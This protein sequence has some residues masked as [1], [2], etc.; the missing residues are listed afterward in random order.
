MATA[1]VTGAT[2]ILG[3]EIVRELSEDSNRWRKVYALSRSKADQYPEHVEHAHLDLTSSA[4]DM[5]KELQ[6][7]DPEYIFFSAYLANEDPDE[8][9]RINGE[10]LENFLES[11]VINRKERRLKRIVLVC[12]L[13]HYGVHL[14]NPKQPMEEDDPWIPEPPAPSNFYYRQQ[15]SL[16][17]FCTRHEIPWNVTYSNE[18]LGYAKGNFMNLAT[19]IALYAAVHAEIG[20]TLPF[21]GPE[22]GYTSFD[23][24]T[25]SRLHAQFCNWVVHEPRARNQAFNTVNG[26]I[27][28]WQNLWPKFAEYFGLRVPADQFSG[29]APDQSDKPMGDQAPITFVAAKMGLNAKE[30]KPNKLRQRIDLKRWS[31]RPEVQDTW[32][33][34]ASRHGLDEDALDRATWDFAAF[35]LGRDF[36]LVANMNKARALG[37]TGYKDSWENFQEVFAEL[38]EG[39]VIPPRT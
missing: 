23:C 15:R 11:F 28:S 5:A 38:A 17:K 31:Q 13:K 20:E 12:G 1:V 22:V 26:D 4:R 21:P 25:S 14:G 8:A 16:Q 2:G 10:M 24:F 39:K 9:T 3:K 32:K 33:N 7:I 19:T 18:V 36:G 37:W 6:H 35:V 29:S 27:E 34:L 30:I